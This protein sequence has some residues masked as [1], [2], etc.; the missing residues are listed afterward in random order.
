MSEK[1]ALSDL[2][3]VV[4]SL[5]EPYA[6][7]VEGVDQNRKD[8]NVI[9]FIVTLSAQNELVSAQVLVGVV[10]VF[11]IFTNIFLVSIAWKKYSRKIFKLTE[12]ERRT[13]LRREGG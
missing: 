4:S 5:N 2:Q 12:E 11:L 13:K 3:P 9:Q 1:S 10:V 6:K 7:S 8:H